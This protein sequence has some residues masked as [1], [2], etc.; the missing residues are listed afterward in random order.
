MGTQGSKENEKKKNNDKVSEH[1][2]AVLDLKNQR[3]RLRQYRKRLETV[4]ERET[5]MAKQLLAEKKRDRALL[6]LKKKRLQVQTLEKSQALVDNIEEMISSVEEAQM[7]LEV[8][9]RLKEGNALLKHLQSQMDLEEIEQIMDDTAEAIAYQNEIDEALGMQLTDEDDEAIEAELA[10][11]VR[12]Q[13][14]DVVTDPLPVKQD[15]DKDKVD[16]EQEE[17]K[18]EE[19]EKEKIDDGTQ[20]DERIAVME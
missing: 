5:E 8:F 11:L 18:E 3:V 10:E 13:L 9:E 1:D 16:K 12:A 20:V 15:K 14:P 19:K 6:C 17:E 2:R 7:Q 4:I